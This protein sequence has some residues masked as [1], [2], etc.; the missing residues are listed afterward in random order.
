M[1]NKLLQFTDLIRLAEEDILDLYRQGYRLDEYEYRNLY[2]N[3][4]LTGCSPFDIVGTAG[5]PAFTFGMPIGPASVP[6]GT[7]SVTFTVLV[8]N[9]GTANGATNCT[10]YEG[11]SGTTISIKGTNTIVPGGTENLTF[12]FSVVGWANGSFQ[13]CAK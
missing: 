7:T 13:I 12:T 8:T 1:E 6:T 9:T 4:L 3:S 10:L 2:I 5:T 11:T